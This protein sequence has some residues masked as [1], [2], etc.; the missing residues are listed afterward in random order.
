MCN[1]APALPPVKPLSKKTLT[2]VL[3]IMT[4]MGL[5]FGAIGKETRNPSFTVTGIILVTPALWLC[6][7]AW[8]KE[9]VCPKMPPKNRTP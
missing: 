4:M 6:V 5:I 2:I 1:Q 9:T 3:F 7:K 8:L